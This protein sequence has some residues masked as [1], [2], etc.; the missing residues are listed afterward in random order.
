M[1]LQLGISVVDANGE[2]YSYGFIDTG[3]AE[4][5]EYG[6]TFDGQDMVFTFWSGDVPLAGWFQEV[7]LRWIKLI[8]KTKNTTT[9]KAQL[10]IYGDCINNAIV[11]FPM[12]IS[13]T[14]SRVT[15]DNSTS[16]GTSTNLSCYVFHSFKCSMTTN[17]EDVGF[18]P[19]GIA[20]LYKEVRQDR[21]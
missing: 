10:S 16:I 21:V 20:L 11:T 19:I 4:R 7:G 2:K 12:K 18:E 8:A 13:N 14:A 3:F 15:R 5:L 17:N 6:K 1:K 9:N